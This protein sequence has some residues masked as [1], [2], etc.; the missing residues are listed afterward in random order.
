MAI[1]LNKQNRGDII[2]AIIKSTF[3]KREQELKS[4]HAELAL[5]AYEAA[6]PEGFIQK[7]KSLPDG[8]LCQYS[9]VDIRIDGCNYHMPLNAKLRDDGTYQTR[10]DLQ[11]PGARKFPASMARYSTPTLNLSTS[12]IGSEVAAM[13]KEQLDAE[14]ALVK[15]KKKN[16]RTS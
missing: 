12:G 7:T 4:K 5:L 16:Y 8:W 1:N 10:S 6:M 2:N 11:L 15:E 14:R 9:M 13:V 3:D